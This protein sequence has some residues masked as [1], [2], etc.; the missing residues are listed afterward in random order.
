[1]TQASARTLL[2]SNLLTLLAVLAVAVHAQEDPRERFVEEMNVT[3]V[4]LDVL[5]TDKTGQV[6]IGLGK[7]DFD[8]KEGGVPVEIT[9]VTFYSSRELM[10][11]KEVLERH[12]L[13]V[14]EIAED[15]YFIIFFQQQRRASGEVPGLL[16]RQMEAA[17]DI[18]TWIDTDLQV[19]DLVA[20]VAFE[21]RLAVHQD[22]TRNV[23]D[24]QTAVMEAAKG[25]GRAQDWPS[26]RPEMGTEPALVANLPQ[27]KELGKQTEDIYEALQVL[28]R[29]AGSIRGRK[30]LL[31]VGRG[32]GQIGGFGFWGPDSRFWGPTIEALNDN[33]LAVY[34]LNLMPLGSR[35]SLEQSLQAIASE[36]GGTYSRQY[37]SFTTPLAQISEE[38][39]GYYLLSYQSR[40]E[41]GESG[42]QK[43][44]VKAR[45]P[46]LRVRAR[47][48]YIFGD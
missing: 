1:M 3:E 6:I 27:G 30:N 32:I 12:G 44:K 20:V 18:N 36:T 16:Q 24:L 37:T 19:H 38:N 48:G 42:F 11:S 26:R 34:P 41:T 23:G 4:L 8:V 7:D 9:G 33:N 5:V 25:Q 47:Q 22:F 45:N 14:D 13:T 28:A 10:G 39:G 2:A 43:V 17:R 40:R 21:T 15:R 29:A 31:F 46:E 35:H